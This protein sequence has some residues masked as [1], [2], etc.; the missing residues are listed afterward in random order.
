MGTQATAIVTQLHN[1]RSA[2]RRMPAYWTCGC[3]DPWTC[4]HRGHAMAIDPEATL[5]NLRHLKANGT[6]GIFPV[7]HLA[8]VSALGEDAR[9]D[10]LEQYYFQT[11]TRPAANARPVTTIQPRTRTASTT[12]RAA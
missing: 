4:P 3:V 9:R 8:A 1:R 5:Q 11:G 12:R 2:A 6:P 7:D 10:A